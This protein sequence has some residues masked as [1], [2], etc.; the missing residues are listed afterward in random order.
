MVRVL[1][2]SLILMQSTRLKCFLFNC[3]FIVNR[4]PD[5]NEDKMALR[6][7][8]G[9]RRGQQG[10]REEGNGPTSLSPSNM[11]GNTWE[12]GF[13]DLE[14]TCNPESSQSVEVR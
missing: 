12:Q 13:L 5:D 4:Y 6:C 2:L 7:A 11:F 3:R 14:K 9:L 8:L 10:G 1:S